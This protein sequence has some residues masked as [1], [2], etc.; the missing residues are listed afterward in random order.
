MLKNILIIFIIQ[1]ILKKQQHNTDMKRSMND[2]F[3]GFLIDLFLL[4]VG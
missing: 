3:L 1:L 4:Y 2:D